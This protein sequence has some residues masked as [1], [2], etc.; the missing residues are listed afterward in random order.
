[1]AKISKEAFLEQEGVKE[2]LEEVASNHGFT[3]DELLNVIQKESDFDTSAVNP[4][5]SATG[6]IQFMPNTA[7]GLGTSIEEISNMSAID[8]LDL[9]DEYFKQNHT[10]G[11]HPYITIAYPKAAKM[12]MDDVIAKPDDSIATQNPVWQNEDGSVTKRSILAYAGYT[13]DEKSKN[14]ILYNNLVKK[15]L[16][17]ESYEHFQDKFS[18]EKA[19]NILYEELKKRKLFSKSAGDFLNTFFPI[20]DEQQEADRRAALSQEE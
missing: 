11:Q 13:E 8:Q 9:V 16:Y 5:S 20:T 19:Q 17:N 3:V 2:K 15:D 18:T 12:D 6:L 1:M 7:K 4:N 10:K 14:E